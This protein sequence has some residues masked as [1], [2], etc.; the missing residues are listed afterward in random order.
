MQTNKPILSVMKRQRS[1]IVPSQIN[2]DPEKEN[3]PIVFAVGDSIA[4]QLRVLDALDLQAKNAAIIQEIDRGIRMVDES[5][6]NLPPYDPESTS[7]LDKERVLRETVNGKVISKSRRFSAKEDAVIIEN[8]GLFGLGQWKLIQILH[9]DD[10]FRYQLRD[11]VSLKDRWLSLKNFK[12]TKY[13]ECRASELLFHD[14]IKKFTASSK[15]T[16]NILTEYLLFTIAENFGLI[17]RQ[18]IKQLSVKL[19]PVKQSQKNDSR[20]QNES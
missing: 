11:N 1:T 3:K 15:I 19:S 5:G 8:V 2:D 12:S 7:Y 20:N 9:W 14:R 4:A 18:S 16:D 13:P 17:P 6:K 10:C